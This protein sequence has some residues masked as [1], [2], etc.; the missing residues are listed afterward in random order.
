VGPD[1]P[2]DLDGVAASATATEAVAVQRGVPVVRLS[3]GQ[4]FVLGSAVVQVLSP[5]ADGTLG[6]E[7]NDNSLVLRVV[8]PDGAL[9]LTGDAEEGA[10]RRLLARPDLLRADTIK[11]PHHGG[12]TNTTGFFDAVGAHTAVIGVGADNGYGHPHP[13]VLD[14]LAGATIVRTDTDG[15]VTVPVSAGASAGSPGP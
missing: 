6:R 12:N 9:L 15:T 5:P 8:S 3:A 14:A 1:P 13:D 7:P 4:Q 10:Q 11:V 2:R